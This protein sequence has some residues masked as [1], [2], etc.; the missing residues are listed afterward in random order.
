MVSDQ[1]YLTAPEVAESLRISV[2]YY[3]SAD[4]FESDMKTR[5]R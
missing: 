1:L 4:K 3:P 2:A 5:R